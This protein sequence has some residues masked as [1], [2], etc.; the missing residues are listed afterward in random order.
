MTRPT[1]TPRRT[2][3]GWLTLI[4]A[5]HAEIARERRLIWISAGAV[6]VGVVLRALEPWPLKFIYNALFLGH[7]HGMSLAVL[8]GLSPEIQVAVYTASMV[9]ITGLAATL[10]YVSTVTMGVA[11]S[12]ILADIRGHLFRHLAHLSVS[13]HGRN[14]TGD[15]ITNVTYDVDRMREVTVSSLLPFLVNVLTLTAMLGV[16]VWMNWK[17]GCIVAVVFPVFFLAVDR[18]M[19]RIKEVAREQ[20]RREGSVASAT[21]ETIGSIRTVQALSLQSRFMDIFS[22][23]NRRSLQAGNKAQQL[24]AGLE[25]VIDLLATSTTA[26]VLWFG[27]RNVFRGQLTPGDLIVFTTYLRTGFKPIRQL[28]KYLGQIARALASGDRILSLLTTPLEIKDEADAVVAPPL[29]GHIIFE[30]VSFE[31]EPQRMA[32]R[33]VS[34]EVKPGQK[35]V[36]AGPSGSGKST[37]A[38]LLLRLHDPC[39]GRILIDGKDIRSCTLESLRS[40]IS[41]VMQD[42]PLFALS[43]RD[44]IALGKTSGTPQEVI[45]AAQIAN[46]H[47]FITRMPNHYDTVLGERG[48]TLSGGQRQRIAIARAAIRRAPIVILDEPT[49]GL[50]RKNEA[51]VSAA[52]DRLS[53]DSTTLLIT[54]DLQ[55]AED[56][57]LVLFLSEGRIVE[58]GTHK[59]L[60]SLDREFASMVHSRKLCNLH[61]E[62]ACACNV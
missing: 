5:F 8:Q 29:K 43:V 18:L 62:A 23:A 47:D 48:A 28:A 30:N 25:R 44:N 40:Q 21:A 16:M 33:N 3:A 31:Y 10:E 17:L 36:L 51:E 7:K 4:R 55:F 11:A 42:S 9:V 12:R 52:L 2:V 22:I 59:S 15:L 14:R 20:R 56:A 61:G 45:Q 13:F 27:V 46:A 57:D 26:L 39:E 60:M 35:V 19:A 24:S 6:L 34:F 38:S 1:T 50:D 32:L 54:H 53:E 37:I 49:T 58:S 41:I